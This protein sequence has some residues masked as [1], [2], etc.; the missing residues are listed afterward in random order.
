[1]KILGKIL[2]KLFL[3]FLILLALIIAGFYFAGMVAY[4][5]FVIQHVGISYNQALGL[6]FNA[7]RQPKKKDPIR[8]Q[9]YDVEKE[10]KS[11]N[12]KIKRHM[13]LDEDIEVD[14]SEVFD[15]L[16]AKS[17]E[18][19]LHVVEKTEFDFS[20]LDQ[21]P[22]DEEPIEEEKPLMLTEGEIAAVIT[23]VLNE[24]ENSP[25][26]KL[27]ESSG[28]DLRHK[29]N[30]NKLEFK[31]NQENDYALEIYISFALKEFLKEQIFGKKFNLPKTAEKILFG[32]V[33][34]KAYCR[35]VVNEGEY[36]KIGINRANK[37]KHAEL[38]NKIAKTQGKD[39]DYLK[40]GNL[41]IKEY[42][43]KAKNEKLYQEVEKQGKVQIASYL[44]AYALKKFKPDT[45]TIPQTIQLLKD[46]KKAVDTYEGFPAF[47][48]E[49][50][51]EFVAL[52]GEL[53]KKYPIKSQIL[54]EIQ[55]EPTLFRKKLT[56]IQLKDFDFSDFDFSK[57]IDEQRLAVNNDVL[58]AMLAFEMKGDFEI[59]NLNLNIERENYSEEALLQFQCEVDLQKYI[60]KQ[61]NKKYEGKPLGLLI[62]KALKAFFREQKCSLGF[63]IVIK[64]TTEGEYVEITDI[65][66]VVLNSL[67]A[68]ET[69]NLI[70]KITNYITAIKSDFDKEKVFDDFINNF[71]ESADKAFGG[72]MNMYIRTDVMPEIKPKLNFV[73]ENNKVTLPSV[74]DLV[75]KVIGIADPSPEEIQKLLYELNTGDIEKLKIKEWDTSDIILDEDIFTDGDITDKEIAYIIKNQNIPGVSVKSTVL[76]NDK[77][78]VLKKLFNKFN[79]SLSEVGINDKKLEENKEYLLITI[80]IDTSTNNVLFDGSD[81]P[82]NLLSNINLTYVINIET[83]NTGGADSFVLINDLNNK[84]KE[85]LAKVV[86]NFG[87]SITPNILQDKVIGVINDIAS[88][89]LSHAKIVAAEPAKGVGRLIPKE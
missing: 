17:N 84:Q 58:A 27:K 53:Q 86:S 42:I 44:A 34:K 71:K 69:G 16:V 78:T 88:D 32:I 6:S 29:I 48:K 55:A 59:E 61:I 1:M 80:E 52:G 13:F 68:E 22:Y 46:I 24:A 11:A 70:D 64:T 54:N 3:V 10:Y 36:I 14:V 66:N 20:Y 85:V 67:D 26:N 25:Y 60:S 30:I 37:N 19:M 21:P 50:F 9:Y 89:L 82:K 5:K 15:V 73:F 77:E 39:R 45:V 40:E 31:K 81:L 56:E 65:Q 7:I 72:I 41:K 63:G 51:D 76:L 2:L 87:G 62:D 49:A 74:Y 23:K 8:Q 47:D 57:N 18:G 12:Q 38:I 28:I 43:D 75:V 83:V 4:N 35:V 79:A 33:P